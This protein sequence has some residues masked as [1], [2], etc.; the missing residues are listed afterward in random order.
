MSGTLFPRTSADVPKIGLVGVANAEQEKIEKARAD[1]A[2]N[3]SGAGTPDS[4]WSADFCAKCAAFA[5]NRDPKRHLS[6]TEEGLRRLGR[7]AE[8]VRHQRH[9]D[10][11][12]SIERVLEV[13]GFMRSRSRACPLKFRLCATPWRRCIFAT[14]RRSPRSSRSWLRLGQR[15]VPFRARSVDNPASKLSVPAGR[16]HRVSHP[17]PL[18]FLRRTVWSRRLPKSGPAEREPL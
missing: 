15:V 13:H 10:R 18:M 2:G 8:A 5:P 9:K 11:A 12:P 1:P 4:G 14:S 17:R 3:H 7:Q 6:P 16:L